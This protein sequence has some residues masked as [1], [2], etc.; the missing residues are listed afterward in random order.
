VREQPTHHLLA[1][2]I[3]KAAAAALFITGQVFVITSIY[4]L[5]ITGTYLG[6]Y[7]GILMS[8][9]VTGFPFNVLN[10]PMYVG[11]AMAFLGT[12][13][14]YESPAG[15]LVSAIVYTVYQIALRFEG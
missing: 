3:V 15:I 13:L 4:A 1:S 2:P 10:D 5:G 11:S 14:W 12:S 6:D 9:R 8:S 7:C